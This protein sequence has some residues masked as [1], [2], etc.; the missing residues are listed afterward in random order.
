MTIVGWYRPPSASKHALSSL[1]E[2]L[3]N[4]KYN[5]L[6][7]TGD[8]NWDWFSPVSDPFK[9]FCDAAHLI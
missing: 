5:E 2:S 7:V 3:A 9:S 1:S 8:L 6:V 4:V